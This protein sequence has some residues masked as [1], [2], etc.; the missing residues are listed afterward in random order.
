MR[1][2]APDAHIVTFP[3]QG[4][5]V[6]FYAILF[7]ANSSLSLF[8]ASHGGGFV[9]IL[10]YSVFKI[11]CCQ[12]ALPILLPFVVPLDIYILTYPEKKSKRFFNFRCKTE[13]LFFVHI[14][15]GYSKGI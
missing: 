9:K 14:D 8:A 2:P 10:F 11:P 6:N 15:K 1:Q 5:A 7:H 13:S 3:F 12:E 4:A